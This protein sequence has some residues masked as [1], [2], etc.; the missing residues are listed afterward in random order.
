M[1]SPMCDANT[2]PATNT[3]TNTNISIERET[4]LLYGAVHDLNSEP[5]YEEV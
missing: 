2:L 1:V 4:R 3:R 5:E